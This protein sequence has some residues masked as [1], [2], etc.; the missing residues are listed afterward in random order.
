MNVDE[1]TGTD[2]LPPLPSRPSSFDRS[3][4][5]KVAEEEMSR[6]RLDLDPLPVNQPLRN[7]DST[8]DRSKDSSTHPTLSLS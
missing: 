8:D 2:P 6:N 5:D 3:L 7:H 4:H 1:L